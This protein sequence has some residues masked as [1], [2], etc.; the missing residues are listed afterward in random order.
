MTECSGV[1]VEKLFSGNFNNESVRKL[2]NVSHAV[3]L[4]IR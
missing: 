3:T 1:G 2:L 4:R